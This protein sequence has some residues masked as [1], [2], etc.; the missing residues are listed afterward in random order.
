MF[1]TVTVH[2]REFFYCTH[3]NGTCHTYLLTACE[4]D[5]AVSILHDMTSHLRRG[6]SLFIIDIAKRQFRMNVRT[7]RYVTEE[8][9]GER[10][11]TV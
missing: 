10:S 7:F 11:D 6:Q 1:R 9:T 8:Q 2:H 5:Q 4:Q 3:S